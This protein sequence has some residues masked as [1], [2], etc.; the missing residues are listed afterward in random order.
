MFHVNFLVS[1]SIIHLFTRF[2]LFLDT[3]T[4]ESYPLYSLASLQYNTIISCIL[5]KAFQI[6]IIRYVSSIYKLLACERI[7]L[8]MQPYL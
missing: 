1:I 3:H 8:K 7:L 4:S 2:D 6:T 5:N